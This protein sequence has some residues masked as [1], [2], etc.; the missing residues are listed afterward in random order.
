MPKIM[1]KETNTLLDR[2]HDACI[3]EELAVPLYTSHI[4]QSLFWSGLP[5]EKQKHIISSLKTLERESEQHA[6]S[7][8]KILSIYSKF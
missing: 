8:K 7:F 4:E 1:K 5:K 2:L 6:K 3:R